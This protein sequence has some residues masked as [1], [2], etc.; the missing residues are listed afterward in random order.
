LTRHAHEGLA[1]SGPCEKLVLVVDDDESLRDSLADLLSDEGYC[2]LTAENGAQALAKLRRWPSPRPCLILLDLMMPVMNG[3]QFVAEQR[4]EP[5]LAR[6]PV[7]VVSADGNL[8]QKAESLG[9]SGWL[10]K[11]I[12]IDSLLALVKR[13]CR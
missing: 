10:R 3:W 1:P 9:A 5:A 8:Q 11:P 13:Y 7:V 6:I 12:E 4:Q 2:I